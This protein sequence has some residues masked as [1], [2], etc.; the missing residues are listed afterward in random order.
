MLNNRGTS[1]IEIV[2]ILTVF[3]MLINFGL[4]F[5]GVI[6]SGILNSIAARNYSFETFRNRAN[7]N[8]LRDL[9]TTVPGLYYNKSGFRRHSILSESHNRQDF[10]ATQRPIKFSELKTGTDSIATSEE[11]LSLVGQIDDSKKVSEIFNGKTRQDGRARVDPVW[12]KTT[13]GICL[14]SACT[15]RK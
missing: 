5:F 8:Y 9:G 14:T 13:Y 2:P 11:H 10:V 7:L 1:A 4:G 12:L 6:H 3:V 15:P